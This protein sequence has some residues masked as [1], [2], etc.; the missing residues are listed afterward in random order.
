MK[1]KCAKG[2]AE[3]VGVLKG[4]GEQANRRGGSSALSLGRKPPAE[5]R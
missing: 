1:E 3:A 2:L 5:E 4:L